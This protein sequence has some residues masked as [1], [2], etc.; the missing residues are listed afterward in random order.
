MEIDSQI[1][2]FSAERLALVEDI[3]KVLNYSV[4]FIFV[5]KRSFY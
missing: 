1:T 5:L 3:D 2:A 4:L